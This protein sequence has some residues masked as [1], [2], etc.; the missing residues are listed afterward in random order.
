MAVF[1][2]E[3]IIVTSTCDLIRSTVRNFICYSLKPESFHVVMT[4]SG[5]TSDDKVGS[6][7][8]LGVTHSSCNIFSCPQTRQLCLWIDGISWWR[9]QMETF[10]ALLALFAGNSPVTGEFPSQRP[11]TRS[12]NVFFDLGLTKRLSKQSKRWW[13][14]TPSC[15]LWRH[16]NVGSG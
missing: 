4:S 13:F 1:D 6:I 9:H 5:V 3:P 10:F 12:F 2:Y 16:R 8:T 15:S 14:E 7:T 11:V